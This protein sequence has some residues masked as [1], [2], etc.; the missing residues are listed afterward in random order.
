MQ[1]QESQRR[2]G[3]KAAFCEARHKLQ[4]TATQRANSLQELTQQ[5][6]PEEQPNK[7]HEGDSIDCSVHS[8]G[9]ATANADS[10]GFGM[11]M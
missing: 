8:G 5:F 7:N 3:I 10:H 11:Y 9:A 6:F 1:P 2:I 4:G